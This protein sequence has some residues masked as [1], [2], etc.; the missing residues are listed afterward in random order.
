MKLHIV[1]WVVYFLT[2]C[3]STSYSQDQIVEGLELAKQLYLKADYSETAKQLTRVLDL[4]N[5][6]LLTKLKSAF[7]EPIGGWRCSDPE[8]KI[9]GISGLTGLTVKRRYFKEGGGPSLDIEM[10][11]NSI[12]IASIKMLFTSPSLVNRAGDNLKISTVANRKCIE[13]F[14][15]IDRYAELTFVPTSTLIVTII[16]QDMKDTQTAI[17]FAEKIKWEELEAIFP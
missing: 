1:F 6:M 4:L 2:I 13:K 9:S 12:K 3:C 5:E 17:K 14:D 10:V 16:G 15:A 11:T 7:P 8:G